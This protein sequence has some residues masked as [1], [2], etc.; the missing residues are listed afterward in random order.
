MGR[1]NRRFYKSEYDINGYCQ[2][3][4]LKKCPYCKVT[5][6]LNLHGFLYGYDET[7]NNRAKRGRRFYCSNRHCRKGCGRTFSLLKSVFLR[8]FRTSASVLWIFIKNREKGKSLAGS[9]KK[10]GLS[11]STSF[12]FSLAKRLTINQS[13]ILT[14]LFKLSDFNI[15]R[16]FFSQLQ[17][18][19]DK[20]NP[21]SAF[22]D[23]FQVDFLRHR[24]QV[25][26]I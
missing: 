6:Y 11:I 25:K 8:F 12:L 19:L 23:Y 9:W 21:I 17:C 22:Q 24:Q 26:Q 13:H 10:T 16:N 18:L 2:E 14:H 15:T 7:Q 1:K 3:I 5:G 20:E 4:K